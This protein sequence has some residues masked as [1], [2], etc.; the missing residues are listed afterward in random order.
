MFVSLRDEI[1]EQFRIQHNE[2]LCDLFRSAS[3]VGAGV[4]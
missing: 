1:T 4:A 3:I 2:V